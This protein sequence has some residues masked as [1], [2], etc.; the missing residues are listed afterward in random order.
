MDDRAVLLQP[1]FILQHR[2]YRESSLI[3][4]VLTRE[5]GVVSIL[6]RGVRKKKSAFAGVLM[7]FTELRLSFQ[8]KGDLK[9]L[10]TAE[11]ISMRVPLQGVALFCGFYVN[12]LIARFLHKHD[13]HPEVYS[14]YRHCLQQ[15]TNVADVEQTLRFFE[16]KLLMYV[17]YALTLTHDSKNDMPVRPNERYSFESGVGI[18][19]DHN[20]YIEGAT[21]LALAEEARLSQPALLEAKRLMRQVLDDHLQGRVL[22]SREVL[23]KVIKFLQ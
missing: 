6:A 4:D 13:P 18:I 12:E 15:L 7:P 17:G 19:R 16:L 8:G 22:K 14:L 5:H 1:A 3:M 11:L 21:L 10:T 23:A 9:V 2:H 20:G